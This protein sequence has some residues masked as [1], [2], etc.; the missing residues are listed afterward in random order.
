MNENSDLKTTEL[1]QTNSVSTNG[2]IESIVNS[3]KSSTKPTTDKS[4][5]KSTGT[6]NCYW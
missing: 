4:E 3:N 6:A 2:D 5:K 1:D